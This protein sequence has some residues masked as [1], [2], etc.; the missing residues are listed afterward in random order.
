VSFSYS[1]A[2]LINC[3]LQHVKF[4]LNGSCWFIKSLLGSEMVGNMFLK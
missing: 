2:F 1:K 3:F 4:I